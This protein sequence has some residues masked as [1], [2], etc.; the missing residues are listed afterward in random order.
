MLLLKACL[1]FFLFFFFFFF[2]SAA[3]SG[4]PYRLSGLLLHVHLLAFLLT[5]F[6]LQSEFR[7]IGKRSRALR[8]LTF[9]HEA[10]QYDGR[11][12]DQLTPQHYES[13]SVLSVFCALF[14]VAGSVQK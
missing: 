5:P 11:S 12:A 2:L 1:F 13:T 3:N 4:S 6:A 9:G 7:V 14:K 10:D 8:E